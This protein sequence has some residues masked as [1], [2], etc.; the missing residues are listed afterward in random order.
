MVAVLRLKGVIIIIFIDDILVLGIT[1]EECS[2]SV[3][4]V[5]DLLNHLGFIIK[6]EKCTLTPSTKFT[7]L[8]CVWDTVL[9]RVGVKEKREIAI[10]KAASD[11]LESESVSVRKFARLLG[12]IRST[13]GFL[14]L[15]RARSRAMG[16]DFS[17]V[18]K[19]PMDYANKFFPSDQT[20][21]E[22]KY[23]A[24]F[25]QGGS[26]LISPVDLQVHSVDTDASPE[27]YG[28]YWQQQLFSDQFTGKWKDMH[29]NIKELYALRQFIIEH[30]NALENSL[31]C[32]RV[33]NNSALAAIKK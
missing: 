25:P 6:P 22:L 23:W 31:V 13:E 27:Y 11:I 21:D 3:K 18:C 9:W 10:R 7:Y 24:T 33:D 4:M 14:P 5:L 2:V 17:A 30:L 15:A 12:K 32:W 28:W 26:C 1:F 19:T 20:R 16:F 29:I 8:G